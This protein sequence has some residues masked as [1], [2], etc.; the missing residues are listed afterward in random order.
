LGYVTDLADRRRR[1]VLAVDAARREGR[2]RS[3]AAL[4]AHYLQSEG[5]YDNAWLL[6][7]PEGQ[8]LGR[9]WNDMS[10]E[11]LNLS[12]VDLLKNTDDDDDDLELGEGSLA[13]APWPANTFLYKTILDEDEDEDEDETRPQGR[14]FRIQISQGIRP[15][16]AEVLA[17]LIAHDPVRPSG[18]PILLLTPHRMDLALELARTVANAIGEPVWTSTG[19]AGLLFDEETGMTYPARFD[20]D[21]GK[22][23]VGQWVVS[24][25]RLLPP[26]G[27]EPGSDGQ[28]LYDWEGNRFWVLDQELITHALIDPV[29]GESIGRSTLDNSEQARAEARGYHSR[30]RS[31]SSV[32]HQ[33][34]AH[35][36]FVPV[37]TAPTAWADVDPALKMY[38]FDGHSDKHGR[39]TWLARINGEVKKLWGTPRSAGG[40]LKRRPSLNRLR[41]EAQ[42]RPVPILVSRCYAAAVPQGV[43]DPLATG[44]SAQI[45]SIEAGEPLYAPTHG[46]GDASGAGTSHALVI[47]VDSRGGLGRWKEFRPEPEGEALEQLARAMGLTTGSGPLPQHTADQAARLVRALRQVFGPTA[48]LDPLLVAGVGALE[49]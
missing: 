26:P 14:R 41:E 48:E 43:V 42:G 29:T 16:S 8:N 36:G 40:Y 33:D 19:R 15:V 21:P 5:A 9:D 45:L 17:E 23:P 35:D 13:D 49:R 3:L 24:P 47:E 37:G 1:A 28:W 12:A 18:A 11:N 46:V 34:P 30:L 20:D 44:E 10:P 6:T 32:Y 25:P 31:A 39:F 27:T 4:E 7:T 22:Q 2:A 38:L